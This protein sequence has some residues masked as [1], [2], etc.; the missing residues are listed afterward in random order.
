MTHPSAPSRRIV[1]IF[2]LMAALALIPAHAPAQAPEGYKSAGNPSKGI[3]LI[4]PSNFDELPIPPD[5]PYLLLKF[6]GPIVSKTGKASRDGMTPP[7]IRI[8]RIP[9]ESVATGENAASKPASAPAGKAAA[10]PSRGT[11]IRSIQDFI[12]KALPG[13]TASEPST[14]KARNGESMTL[15]R[16]ENKALGMQGLIFGLDDGDDLI[17]FAGLAGAAAFEDLE[18]KFDRSARYLVVKEAPPAAAEIEKMYKTKPYRNVEYRVN[19][20]AALPAG[21]KADDTENFILVYNVKDK[22][23]IN[24]MKRDLEV[25]RTKFVE[26]FPPVRTIEAVSTVRVCKSRD[27]FLKFSEMPPE[28]RVAGF[29]NVRSKELVFYN[30]VADPSYPNASWEDA[31]IVLYH[32]AFH[33]YIYYACG[34]LDP[35]S[36]FNE[37]YGDYFSGCRIGDTGTRVDRI[38]VNPWRVGTVK[39]MVVNKTYAPLK[40]LVRFEQGAYYSKAGF[41]YAQGWSLIYFLND[42]KVIKRHPLWGRILPVYLKTL[43]NVNQEEL[44]KAGANPTGEQVG[45]ARLAAR[46]AAVDAAFDGI[47]FEKLEAEWSA[48]VGQL[49]DPRPKK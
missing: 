3:S 26:L 34:E 37:G 6:S 8:F 13:Y 24:K 40:D 38:Q 31:C 44:K 9:E 39:N 32:E 11:G 22:T 47:D 42:A 45:A 49:V 43:I 33:Q 35:H 19:V 25:L 7:E 5:N 15:S 29:W 48:F 46:K 20:R 21:W 14:T 10:P 2:A 27:E 12:K 1:S 17:V 28:S 23:L 16:V 30:H 18:K 4:V 41:Y 36:W